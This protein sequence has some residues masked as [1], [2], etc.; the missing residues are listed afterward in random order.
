MNPLIKKLRIKEHSTIVAL[1]APKNYEATL[2]PLPEGTIVKYKL[3]KSNDFVHLFVQDKAELELELPKVLSV[4]APEAILCIFYPKQSSGMQ[5]DLTRDN[6]W[7]ILNGLP[8]QWLSLV[9]FDTQWSVFMM[10]N[11]PPKEK[12]S[13]AV[14]DYHDNREQYADPATKTVIVPEDLAAAFKEHRQAKAAY[15]AL[16]YSH[17]KEY[18]LWIVGAKREETRQGRVL[19]TIAMLEQAKKNPADK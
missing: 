14:A 4:L 17:R 2:D 13:S 10:R 12:R 1:H 11:T 15:E 9:S 18:V 6:G 3:S 19:K 5:T 8:M 16:A 7:E